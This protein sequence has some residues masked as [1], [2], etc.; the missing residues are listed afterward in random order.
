MGGGAE[1]GGGGKSGKCVSEEARGVPHTV[2][3][4]ELETS[5]ETFGVVLEHRP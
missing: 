4:A 3:F 2:R 5:E 1:K